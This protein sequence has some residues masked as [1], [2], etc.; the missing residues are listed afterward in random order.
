FRESI[1]KSIRD[2]RAS[3]RRSRH[4]PLPAV[5]FP[6]VCLEEAGE[7]GGEE[8]EGDGERDLIEIRDDDGGGKKKSDKPRKTTRYMTKYER[9]RVLGARALQI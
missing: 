4:V 2:V 5:R 8:G 7:E 3:D 6:S 1:N 9:A